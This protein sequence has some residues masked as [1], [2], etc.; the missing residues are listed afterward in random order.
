MLDDN[1]EMRKKLNSL[2]VPCKLHVLNGIHHG[3]LN[4]ITVDKY[5]MKASKFVCTI[6]K[7]LQDTILN[8]KQAD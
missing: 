4:F 5:C 1:I 6:I 2:F 8:V 7:I 3:F